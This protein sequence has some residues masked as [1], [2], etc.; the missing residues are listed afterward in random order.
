MVQ[1]HYTRICG[2]SGWSQREDVVKALWSD[3]EANLDALHIDPRKTRIYQD[4]LPICGFEDKI[5]RELANAGSSNHQLILRWVDQ[6]ATLMGTEDAQLLMEEYE[7]QKQ[8]F[9]RRAEAGPVDEKHARHMD[10]VLKSRDL[11]IAKRIAA[12]L[13]AG[14]VGLLFLGALH[15]LDALRCDDIRVETLGDT[16]HKAVRRPRA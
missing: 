4:G 8:Q 10:S 12:T 15:R 3:I 5:V 11:F 13:E 1:E 16:L 9:A 6:G 2:K 7:L 14:E